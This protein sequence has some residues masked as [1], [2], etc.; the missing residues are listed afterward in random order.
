MA[1]LRLYHK[2]A[3]VKQLKKD[4]AAAEVIEA[5]LAKLKQ[6]RATAEAA[7]AATIIAEKPFNRNSK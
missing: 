5:E 7:R 6:L 4:G 1:G 2:G 3:V